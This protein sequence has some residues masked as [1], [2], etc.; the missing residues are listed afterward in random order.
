MFAEAINTSSEDN[1]FLAISSASL[2]LSREIQAK[3]MKSKDKTN[4]LDVSLLLP[5]TPFLPQQAEKRKIS[6][7]RGDLSFL[8]SNSHRESCDFRLF[9]QSDVFSQAFNSSLKP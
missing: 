3:E 1:F 8:N 7:S 4:R 6:V 9:E 5:L 2:L